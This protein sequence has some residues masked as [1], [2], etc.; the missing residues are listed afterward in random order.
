MTRGF[1]SI[2]FVVLHSS[3]CYKHKKKKM[4]MKQKA[5]L[6]LS[7][8]LLSFSTMVSA[9]DI[10]VYV[11]RSNSTAVPKIHAWNSAGQSFT[12][13]GNLPS[14]TSIG[15][16]WFKYTMVN[17]TSIG[18][19]I[20]YNDVE[21]TGDF[22]FY[23]SDR[24]IVLNADG[25]SGIAYASNPEVPT[26]TSISEIG[27]F[28]ADGISLQPSIVASNYDNI[29]YTLDGS[30]PQII[31]TNTSCMCPTYVYSS[32]YG[33][34]PNT[35]SKTT[36][37]KA[38][39]GLG[40][41]RSTTRTEQYTFVTTPQATVIADKAPQA[42]GSYLNGQSVTITLSSN[43][44]N[45]PIYY[46]LDG[47]D[48]LPFQTYSSGTILYTGSFTTVRTNS[49]SRIKVMV[50]KR[51]NPT[52][53]ADFAGF[54][55]KDLVFKPLFVPTVTIT[56]ATQPQ[57]NGKYQVYESVS[58][59]LTSNFAGDIYYTTDGSDIIDN[60]NFGTIKKFVSGS[61]IIVSGNLSAL[62][63]IKAAVVVSGTVGTGSALFSQFSSLDFKF[64]TI[65]ISYTKDVQPTEGE[66]C[67]NAVVTLNFQSNGGGY[68]RYIR[69]TLDGSDP[70]TSSTYQLVVEALNFGSLYAQLQI[71]GVN[72]TVK[73]R[74]Y[75]EGIYGIGPYSNEVSETFVFGD[76]SAPNVTIAE[77]VQPIAPDSCY[78]NGQNVTVS[79]GTTWG[80][81]GCSTGI[82]YTLDGTN[83][84]T[85]ATKKSYNG[86]FVISNSVKV[87][88]IM[89]SW[90]GSMGLAYSGGIL[91]KSYCFNPSKGITIHVKRAATN[92]YN[93]DSP[94]IHV[95][96]KEGGSDV[97]LTNSSNW[98]NNLPQTT[99]ENNGWSYYSVANHTQLGCLFYYPRTGF[100]VQSNDF[101]YYNQD[102]WILLNVDGKSG[103]VTTYNP[104]Y[105]TLKSGSIVDKAA[106]TEVL[107]S[108]NPTRD[109]LNVNYP[110]EGEKNV[111]V[112]IT[113]FMGATLYS[114]TISATNGFTKQISLSDYK[115]V[116][117]AYI[118]V[119][120]T[121][122][123]EK[124]TKKFIYLND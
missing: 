73:F 86:P 33:I 42:D 72:Q 108:P 92:G 45:N 81:G 88:A 103:I 2:S 23:S 68:K 66:Y 7:V 74:G 17:Q 100:T 99:V 91:T 56:P 121:S 118:L 24:W 57:A 120:E 54:V 38:I 75:E 18:V 50:A 109:V 77:D 48:V 32:T 84:K 123:G 69:Y 79:L 115:L 119:I 114:E 12:T 3:K 40:N 110:F 102:I 78:V 104:D 35:I 26:I 14:M 67:N 15:S 46:T 1:R 94:R 49:T 106:S 27:G 105:G 117:G 41:S 51:P 70:K 71:T 124:V 85:S 22:K 10:N 101:K 13:W 80:C 29:F 82:D 8:L 20:Y 59:N 55:L 4:I 43:M 65:E 11:K 111:T 52:T 98:P 63:R 93:T 19:V 83:P 112:T 21:R 76:C 113:S 62:T 60:P 89:T 96:T 95:W 97:A 116:P 122:T 34:A 39:A 58:V 9:T 36:S 31:A 25:K 5:L 61:P 16:G 30:E 37:L 53:N 6:L 44:G 87:R 90:G 107:L 64:E 47:S 28:Y